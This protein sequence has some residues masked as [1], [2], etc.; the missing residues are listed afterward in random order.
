MKFEQGHV[1]RARALDIQIETIMQTG[2]VRADV[3]VEVV[4]GPLTG[5]RMRGNLWLNS[6]ENIE[7]SIRELRATGWTGDAF[8]DK[9]FREEPD[10]WPG[11]GMETFEFQAMKEESPDETTGE[12]RTFWRASFFRPLITLKAKNPT[13]PGAI[14]DIN[15]RARAALQK[16]ASSAPSSEAS[17]SRANGTAEMP[18]PPPNSAD[19]KQDDIP[20]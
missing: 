13:A 9:P 10:A 19:M 18:P 3:V 6:P 15:R 8:A 20:F 17:P 5:R 4:M 7:R 2:T 11:F 12:L 14:E 1:Y 16:G